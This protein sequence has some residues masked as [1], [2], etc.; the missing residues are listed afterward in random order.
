MCHGAVHSAARLATSLKRTRQVD[1]IVLSYE[2]LRSCGY[3][4]LQEMS[5]ITPKG[6]GS[7]TLWD[8]ILSRLRLYLGKIFSRVVYLLLNAT[9]GMFAD[10]AC[11]S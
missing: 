7:V 3:V 1:A 4:K 6:N 2:I 11:D 5:R 9:Q 8:S 10:S